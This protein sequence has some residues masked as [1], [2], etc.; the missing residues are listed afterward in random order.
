MASERERFR[1][2]ADQPPRQEVSRTQMT[3][4]PDT[5]DST[6]TKAEI[7]E[8]TVNTEHNENTEMTSSG[9]TPPVTS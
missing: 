9:A 5:A 2:M 7:A 6:E 1:M 8:A 4:T 3:G